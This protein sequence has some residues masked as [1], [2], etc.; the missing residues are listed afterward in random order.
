MDK[1]GV[2]V[3]AHGGQ[4]DAEE[5]SVTA[6]GARL[7]EIEVILFPLDGTLGTGTGIFVA[8]PEGAI[9]GDEGVHSR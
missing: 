4:H 8:L 6:H 1:P 5:P 2:N 3:L 7:E 9:S